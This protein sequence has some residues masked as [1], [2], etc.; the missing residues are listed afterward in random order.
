MTPITSSRNKR[1]IF[2]EVKLD[3][4]LL[5]AR[6]VAI[7]TLALSPELR[8]EIEVILPASSMTSMLSFSPDSLK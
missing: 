4:I 3:K 8:F 2:V 7:L 6:I 1:F 5:I